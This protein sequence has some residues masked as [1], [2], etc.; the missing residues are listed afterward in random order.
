MV[1]KCAAADRKPLDRLGQAFDLRRQPLQLSR[2]VRGAMRNSRRQR[3]QLDTVR[4]RY[5]LGDM[6]VQRLNARVN[7]LCCENPRRKVTSVME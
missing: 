5:S 7:A 1:G 4:V 2:S 3:R 6:P